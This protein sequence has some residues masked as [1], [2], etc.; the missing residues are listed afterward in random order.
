MIGLIL[1]F[2]YSF[3]C[4]NIGIWPL[5]V[6][7]HSVANLAA[8]VTELGLDFPG[9]ITKGSLPFLERVIRSSFFPILGPLIRSSSSNIS[10]AKD[11]LQY[12]N[13]L[14]WVWEGLHGARITKTHLQGRCHFQ[15]G[16]PGDHFAALHQ[17]QC[18]IWLVMQMEWSEI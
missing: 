10:S 14:C 13:V 6:I 4:G 8:I 17:L 11:I 5:T 7:L 15:W 18:K 9:S 1:F 16:H 2:L 12:S 3:Q